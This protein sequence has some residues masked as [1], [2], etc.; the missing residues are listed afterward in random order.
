MKNLPFS[1]FLLFAF[2]C[3]QPVTQND[4]TIAFAQNEH[5]FGTLR[6]NQKAVYA[7]AF[8][9]PGSSPIIIH[10]VETSCGCTVPDWPKEPIKPGKKGKILIKYDTSHPWAFS[11]SITVYYNGKNSPV[12][13]KI[14]GEVG[15]PVGL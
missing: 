11:K 7:F 8:S 9:N 14:K 10:N 13:L 15:Y 6:Q 4:A 3:S 2:S 1:I 12:R 5:D